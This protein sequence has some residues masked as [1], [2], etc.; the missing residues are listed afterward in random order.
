MKRRLR[1]LVF[2]GLLVLLLAGVFAGRGSLGAPVDTLGSLDRLVRCQILTPKTLHIQRCYGLLVQQ[3][4]PAQGLDGKYLQHCRTHAASSS[5]ARRV[6]LQ[7]MNRLT[8]V[9]AY[10][11]HDSALLCVLALL[12]SGAVMLAAQLLTT[13]QL[14]SGRPSCPDSALAGAAFILAAA[15]ILALICR[16]AMLAAQV[17]VTTQLLSGRPSRPDSALAGATGILTL[18]CGAAM[19]AAQVLMTIQLLSGRPSRPAPGSRSA[20]CSRGIPE[21]DISPK[22]AAISDVGRERDAHRRRR[23]LP[24]ALAFP[25]L[26]LCDIFVIRH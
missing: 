25:S 13:T 19:L 11:F 14:L 6:S 21:A 22:E 26:V 9:S 12:N 7:G 17:L 23:S 24:C 4:S 15:C 3:P 20:S 8:A 5:L 2:S 1:G 16:A 18:I 10:S